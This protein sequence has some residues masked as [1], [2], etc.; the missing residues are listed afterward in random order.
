MRNES[1]ILEVTLRH[2]VGQAVDAI[3]VAD[4]GSTD[5]TADII[6]SLASEGLPIYPAK[7][8]ERQYYQGIKITQLAHFAR[9]AKASWVI[10]FD[11]DE[12]WFADDGLLGDHLRRSNAAIEEAAIHNMAPPVTAK[13]GLCS[14]SAP[15]WV[16]GERPAA[17]HKVAFRPHMFMRVGDGNHDVDRP[18]PRTSGLR[19]AHVPY[20]SLEQFARKVRQ[21]VPAL[22]DLEPHIG[23]HWRTLGKLDDS[24]LRMLWQRLIEGDGPDEIGWFPQGRLHTVDVTSWTRWGLP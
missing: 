18:G 24:E 12:L 20:R 9:R 10:P 13:D 21:G 22:E 4:N 2:L 1:D 7:D 3:L 8:T 23:V 6:H 19:V 17:L 5:A 14:L 16:I 15:G 11:A